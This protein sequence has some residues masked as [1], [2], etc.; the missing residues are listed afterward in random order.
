MR[1]G[2]VHVA[3][4]ASSPSQHF[5]RSILCL[6]LLPPSI[7]IVTAFYFSKWLKPAA[8]PRSDITRNGTT[9]KRIL[10]TGNNT[11][12]I[13]AMSRALHSAGHDVYVVDHE[14]IP[15]ANPL[16]SS[17]AITK[18]VN[19]PT[20]RLNSTVTAMK[21]KFFHLGSLINIS[22]DINQRQPLANLLATILQLIESDNIE[23]WIPCEANG[24]TTILQTKEVITKHSACQIY[25]PDFEA[26]R[27]SQNQERFSQ[28]VER[29]GHSIRFPSAIVVKSRAEIHHLLS[30][31]PTGGKY[32]IEKK[33]LPLKA[34]LSPLVP[35]KVEISTGSA[36]YRSPQAHGGS[37]VDK[38]YA[39]LPLKT[40][41]E[42][43]SSVAALTISC[44][45]PWLMHQVIEGRSIS[46]SAL[47]VNNSVCAFTASISSQYRT[48][49]PAR[50]GKM[51]NGQP[52][53]RNGTNTWQ[54][55][56]AAQSLDLSSA[57]SQT[58]SDFA[59]RFAREL[60]KK[61]N[62]QLNLQFIVAENATASG[63]LQKIWATGCD[64]EVTPL[65]FQRAFDSSQL[66]SVGAAYS[67]ALNG[68]PMLLPTLSTTV[69]N[70]H[71]TSTYSLPLAAYQHVCVPILDGFLFRASPKD[72]LTGLA[73]FFNQV[74]FGQEDLFSANDSLPWIWSWFIQF[75]IQGSLE[76]GD[77]VINALTQYSKKS[78]SKRP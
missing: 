3:G 66:A 70:F 20:G 47:V 64:F 33:A 78:T 10:V 42:T 73:L 72:V 4:Q 24:L 54:Q 38:E 45:Q 43:Y 44:D 30:K 50:R 62:A 52:H 28:H 1:A 14:R 74:A 2:E 53:T 23:L 22:F 57:M 75:P 67:C 36:V 27:I 16:R 65:L 49:S 21:T 8:L 71:S 60:P 55:N 6:F 26:I 18:F 69:D 29:L 61:T 63:V 68:G 51:V 39:V 32:L 17:N 46:A 13:L 25:G 56:D 59:E 40:L 19:L 11:S 41:N 5:S 12:S 9:A 35:G 37:F 31:N 7:V 34:P 58:L 48:F 15:F 77:H 76:F